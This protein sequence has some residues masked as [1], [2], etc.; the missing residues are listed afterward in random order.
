MLFVVCCCRKQDLRHEWDMFMVLK[1]CCSLSILVYFPVMHRNRNMCLSRDPSTSR[2]SSREEWYSN[3]DSGS[4][5]D[6]EAR[7]TYRSRRRDS[8]LSPD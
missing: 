1:P 7:S 3:Y 2:K 6:R 8:H 4:D 5:Y